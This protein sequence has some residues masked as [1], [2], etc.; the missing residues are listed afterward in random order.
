MVS[1]DSRVQ[2]GT[3]PALVFA[4]AEGANA[5]RQRTSGALALSILSPLAVAS[6]ITS[7]I[8]LDIAFSLRLVPI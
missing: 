8:G 3:I 1:T 7:S 5:A 6:A 2:M 4:R